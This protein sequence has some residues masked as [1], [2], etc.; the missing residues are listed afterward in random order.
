MLIAIVSDIHGNYPALEAAVKD[1]KAKGARKIFCAGDLTG[2]GP[3]P[4]EVVDFVKSRRIPTVIGNYDRKLLRGKNA[5]QSLRKKMKPY[6]WKILDWTRDQIGA[7]GRRYLGK[8]PEAFREQV[9][10]RVDL[11]MVHGSPISENDTILPSITPAAL[12]KKMN[13]KPPHILVCGHTHIPFVKRISNTLV[14][15]CGSAGH[16]VDGDPRPAYALVR[17]E[18]ASKPS[19]R[20]VRFEY[21]VEQVLA[22]IENS[23]LPNRLLKDFSEGNKKRETP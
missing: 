6:K 20:I 23:S 16:P 10:G 3:F 15:N 14:V 12:R 5:M 11:M 19:A 18:K 8:L 1:A 21:P 17:I 13:C 22:A 4:A 9:Y 2:Y 7:K